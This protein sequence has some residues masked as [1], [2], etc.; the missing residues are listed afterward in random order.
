MLKELEEVN[1]FIIKKIKDKKSTDPFLKELEVYAQ[2]NHVPIVTKEVA[3]YLKFMADLKKSKRI[4]EI[5]TAIGY[6]GIILAKIAKE[7]K[8]SLITI[9]KN[10]NMYDLA[11]ENFKK[12]KLDNYIDLILGDGKEKMDELEGKFDFIFID[13]SK[14]QYKHFFEK[15]YKLLEKN[16]IIFIDNI[17]FKGY[18]YSEEYPKRYKTIVKRLRSFIDKLYEEDYKFTLMPFGDGI[19]LVSK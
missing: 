14:G 8:G 13:A 2:N 6:S 16:G 18:I 3:E 19:G 7:N 11:K 15:A 1:N 12:A 4:L 5:G 17:L 10:K 9:E